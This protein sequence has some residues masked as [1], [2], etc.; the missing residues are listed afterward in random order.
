MPIDYTY[1]WDSI[2]RGCF[3]YINRVMGTIEGV[4]AYTLDT[5]PRTMPSDDADFFIWHFS[6]NGGAVSVFRNDR[7][8]LPGGPFEMDA[9]FMASCSTDRVAKLVGGIL[10]N[11][12]PAN[13]ADVAGLGRL[14]NT[15]YP[16]RER[17]TK[18][19]LNPT[20]AGDERIFFDVTVPLRAIFD[21]VERTT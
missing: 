15:E 16:S 6:I 12:L 11:A 3:E 14:Y 17:T 7:T 8:K 4:T 5:F 2:E 18:P 1:S 9:E 10:L 13:N 20:R 19:V 21:N